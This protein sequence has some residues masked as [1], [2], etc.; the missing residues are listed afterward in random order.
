MTISCDNWWSL[1]HSVAHSFAFTS[2]KLEGI[3]CVFGAPSALLGLS[4]ANDGATVS[5][6]G[7][8]HPQYQ[9]NSNWDRP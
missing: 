2:A 3:N 1:F 4:S 6:S 9:K 7:A 5:R 8:I